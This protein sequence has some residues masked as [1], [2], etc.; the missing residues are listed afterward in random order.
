MYSKELYKYKLNGNPK[1]EVDFIKF[2][3]LKG[4]QT[5]WK[6]FVVAGLLEDNIIFEQVLE[7]TKN[8][9]ANQN[10]IKIITQNITNIIG[11]FI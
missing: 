4:I 9:F 1:L 8:I 10:K 7:N 5:N 6:A 11:N 2:W 3:N